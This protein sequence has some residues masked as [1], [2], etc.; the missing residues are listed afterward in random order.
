MEDNKELFTAEGFRKDSLEHHGVKNQKWGVR[1]YQ[2]QDGSLTDLGRKHWGV[3][4]GQRKTA[5]ERLKDKEE[6]IKQKIAANEVKD[7]IKNLKKSE[8]E[9]KTAA[10]QAVREQKERESAAKKAAKDEK[11]REAQRKRELESKIKRDAQAE[12]ERAANQKANEKLKAKK[13]KILKDGSVKDILKNKNLFTAQELND[14]YLRKTSEKKLDSIRNPVKNKFKDMFL[15][16][17]ADKFANFSNKVEKTVNSYEKLSNSVNKIFGQ[18]VIPKLPENRNEN[19]FSKKIRTMTV[20]DI[21][22]NIA[23]IDTN[24]LQEWNKRR[25]VLKN[26][27]STYYDRLES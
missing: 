3:G 13:D 17:D 20:K 9:K 4:S 5:E 16:F 25:T 8:K 24:T 15:T 6:K 11:E 7:R 23:D 22:D 14:A 21:E 18:T 19:L 27:G 1:R 12:K 2:N 26:A 10:K